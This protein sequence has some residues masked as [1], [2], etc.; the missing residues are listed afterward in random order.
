MLTESKDRSCVVQVT[1]VTCESG[2]DRIWLNFR[3]LEDTEAIS[4]NGAWV[5]QVRPGAYIELLMENQG[6]GVTMSVEREEVMK[7]I[8][9]ISPYLMRD[10]ELRVGQ[11]K[12]TD[13][14]RMKE[15]LSVIDVKLSVLSKVVLHLQFEGVAAANGVGPAP[16][17][18][19]C[20]LAELLA[21]AN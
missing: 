15:S 4:K 17:G 3:R 7:E 21:H 19:G 1:P 8:G 5:Y 10:V 2:G 13:R 20:L 9:Q 14:F 18:V 6:E 16:G 12:Y 11:Q